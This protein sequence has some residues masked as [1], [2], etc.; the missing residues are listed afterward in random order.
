MSRLPIAILLCILCRESIFA[1]TSTYVE[2]GT[3]HIVSWNDW[4][5]KVVTVD[6]LAWGAY[7]KGL[8]QH[9]ILPSG[10]VYIQDVDYLKHDLNG[11]LLRVSGYLRKSRV[12]KAP[13][14]AQGYSKPFD[15]FSIET[16]AVERIEQ[17]QH[18]QLLPSPFDWI[19]LG[20]KTE[21]ALRSLNRLKYQK[22]ALS[23]TPKAGST[24]HAYH[25]SDAETLFFYDSGGRITSIGRIKLNDPRKRIDDE[26][27][28][29]KA[30]RLLPKKS[31]LPPPQ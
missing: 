3:K 11:R 10:R 4:V 15:Y 16:F 6:G 1:Q 9:L 14:K 7:D 13:S 19:V 18:D 28:P 26:G 21:D 17:I 2:G 25:V 27:I 31:D 5:G 24:P 29:V 8:G 12:K 23:L 30:Y 20:G 22:V